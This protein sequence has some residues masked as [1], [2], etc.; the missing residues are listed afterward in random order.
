M[1]SEGA[2]WGKFTELMA[3]H[4]L[5]DVHRDKPLPIMDGNRVAD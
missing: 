2:C 5:S 1:T 4:I 3:D